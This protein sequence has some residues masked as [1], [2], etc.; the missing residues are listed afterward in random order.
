MAADL[1]PLPYQPVDE[2][3]CEGLWGAWPSEV[4]GSRWP[5]M[6]LAGFGRQ[7]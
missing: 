1:V 5:V 6:G 3:G 7:G 2:G 4:R